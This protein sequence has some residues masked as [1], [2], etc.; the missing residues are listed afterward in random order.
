MSQAVVIGSIILYAVV[1]FTIAWRADRT[2][3]AS[4]DERSAALPAGLVF[5]LSLAVYCTSWTFYGAVGTARTSGIEYLPI[6]LGPFLIFSAGYKIIRRIVTT[7]KRIHST[8]IADFMSAHYQKSRSVA[9]LV[10]LIAVIGALP[11]IALQLKSVATS[12]SFI[13]GLPSDE[14]AG[15]GGI[16]IVAVT[17]AVFAVM[18]GTRHIDITRHNRG[19][20]AAIAFDS[21]FKLVAL[22]AVGLFA[23]LVMDG[24]HPSGS[25]F[26]A[27]RDPVD[28]DRFITLTL[29][30]MAAVLCLPRQFHVTVVECRDTNYLKNG[31]LIFCIYL[32]VISIVVIPIVNSAARIPYVMNAPPD[33]TVLALPL[34]FGSDFIALLVFV[35]GF[36]AATGMVIVASV[37]LSTMITNDLVAPFFLR[38]KLASARS[39]DLWRRLLIIRRCSIVVLLAGASLFAVYAPKGEQLSSFGILSFAA[40]AQ[41]MPALMGALYWKGVKPAAALA[42]MGTGFFLWGLLLL[43]PA[44]FGEGKGLS[45]FVLGILEGTGWDKLS[46]GVFMSL[47][48]NSLIFIAVAVAL[49]RFAWSGRALFT[50]NTKR[51]LN[52]ERV[53][54]GDL[55]ILIRQCLGEQEANRKIALFEELHGRRPDPERIAGPMLIAFVDEQIS[56]AIGASS[57]SILLKSVLA[58]GGL[59]LDDVVTLLGETSGRVQFSRDLLQTTLENI[60][61]GVSVVDSDLRLVAWNAAYAEMYRYP[62]DLLREGCPVATLIRYNAGCGECGPGSVDGHVKRRLTHLKA[63]KRHAFERTRPDGR[64]VKIEG[65]QSPSGA[66]VT[67][68]TD[69]TD[70]KRIEKAL[71]DSE[72]S[73]RFYTDNIPAMASFADAN[74]VLRFANS[75]YRTVFQVSENDIDVKKL[76]EILNREDY[77]QRKCH[78]DR[79]LSGHRSTFDIE[80][81]HE[82]QLQAMQVTYVPEFDPDGRVR[83]FFGIYQDVTARREAEEALART[84]ETLEDRVH[85]RTRELIN[86]NAALE[87][88]RR[89]AEE[90]TASKTRFLAAASHDV[91]QPLN[92]ARLFTSALIEADAD[93]PEI[94]DLSRKIDASIASADRLL[95]SLLDISKL[96]AGG[97]SPDISDFPL[98]ELFAQVRNDFTMMANEKSIKLD[99]LLTGVWVRSDRDLLLSALQ[100][101]VSNAV[102]YTDEGRIFVGVR[103]AGAGLRIEVYDTGRGIPEH[104]RR[105]IFREFRRLDRDKDISGAGL[106]LAMVDRICRLL[107]ID[108]KLRSKDGHGS[109]FAMTVPRASVNK[110]HPHATPRVTQCAMTGLDVIC[111]DN[112]EMVLAGMESVLKRWGADV[113]TFQS[114]RG[115]LGGV[116]GDVATMPDLLILDYQLDHGRTG[117][118]ALMALEAHWKARPVTIMITASLSGSAQEEAADMGIPVLSK[119]VEPAQLR[120]LINHMWVRAAE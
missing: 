64:V 41:Y 63:G 76:A 8:S 9:A 69:V 10:S 24:P 99:V 31:S 98:D 91:L 54:A 60:S 13:T 112:D 30:S 59:Q 92:A 42:A 50:Q 46:R 53:R 16:G 25:D 86:V 22:I 12:F 43:A 4:P 102:R 85:A 5:G 78:I 56:K 110:R 34:A 39:D 83:G 21:V 1:M 55:Y 27:S 100:N 89:E 37:A 19:M 73:I 107:S 29:L 71:I 20:I 103:R 105:E 93:N 95:R 117:F 96:D 18:F 81:T 62:P 3:Q 106:G 114:D 49:D 2:G 109:V 77:S 66:Y 38:K 65:V 32:I 57:A 119:P 11:Y 111:I 51:S 17:L 35:G 82:G 90:A 88:A 28:W 72:R 58:G 67:T 79:A 45:F 48:A 26:L 36:A 33:L 6:Y 115:A 47:A 75:V 94:A 80:L 7:G 15:L 116:S 108:L 52:D 44:Y 68:F 70:Y 84:N 23:V 14:S 120:A 97:I 61:T 118:D 74:E 101:I 104:R 87:T 40:V 113:R